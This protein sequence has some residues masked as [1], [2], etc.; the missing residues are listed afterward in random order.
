[1]ARDFRNFRHNDQAVRFVFQRVS[2]FG[3]FKYTVATWNF[4][5]ISE[6]FRLSAVVAQVFHVLKRRTDGMHF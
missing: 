3:M 4:P 1:M 2:H 6:R 5:N